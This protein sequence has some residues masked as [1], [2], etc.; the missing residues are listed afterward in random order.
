MLLAVAS[1]S[2]CPLHALHPVSQKCQ[3]VWVYD[4]E[5]LWCNHKLVWKVMDD[6]TQ[7]TF[8]P[9]FIFDEVDFQPLL[10]P[11]GRQE[12]APLLKNWGQNS[13]DWQCLLTALLR[14]YRQHHL[15]KV[16]A[17]E[18]TRVAFELSTMMAHDEDLEVMLTNTTSRQA[19]APTPCVCF[20]IPLFE[21]D[22]MPLLQF[23]APDD[24]GSSLGHEPS[25]IFKL[26][27]TYKVG[28]KMDPEVVLQAPPSLSPLSPSLILPGWSPHMCMMEYRP[29]L[30]EKLQPQVRSLAVQMEWRR[31][32]VTH[33]IKILGEPVEV[34]LLSGV[35]S[36]ELCWDQVLLLLHVEMRKLPEEPPVL[37]LQGPRGNGAEGLVTLKS[38]CPWD[39]QAYPQDLA[40]SVVNHLKEQLPAV[41]VKIS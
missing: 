18:D 5:L 15:A 17:L 1:G 12:V 7:P 40:A 4:L 29:L 37:T 27:V 24:K 41:I 26:Y 38:G 28:T 10:T 25:H 16:E 8:P 33:L 11:K 35:V 39:P 6:V 3:N 14:L 32:L 9:D 2:P 31:N 23:L 36:F 34:N 21:L 30:V 22:V 19:K 13:N 20:G